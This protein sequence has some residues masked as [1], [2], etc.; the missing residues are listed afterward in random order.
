MTAVA[1]KI[2]ELVAR[3]NV[4]EFEFWDKKNISAGRRA[5][6]TLQEIK[7]ICSD[8]RFA[9]TEAKKSEQQAAA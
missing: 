5:R 6:K 7:K 2:R 9:I 4:D 3:L 8:A 1:E